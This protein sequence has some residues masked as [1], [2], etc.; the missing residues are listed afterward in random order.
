MGELSAIFQKL[1]DAIQD[2]EDKNPV[3]W[4][5][6]DGNNGPGKYSTYKD[7]FVEEQKQE[8]MEVDG[9][10]GEEGEEGED[11]DEGGGG[12]TVKDVWANKLGTEKG[13]GDVDEAMDVEDDTLQIDLR[14]IVQNVRDDSEEKEKWRTQ[15]IHTDYD[16]LPMSGAKYVS[17]PDPDSK[18]QG[19]TKPCADKEKTPYPTTSRNRTSTTCTPRSSALSAPSRLTTSILGSARRRSRCSTRWPPRP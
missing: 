9:E 3:G 1:S 12:S 4:E 10:E 18:L 14:I 11:D 8:A 17:V 6:S 2:A 19:A 15:V 13:G 5:V 7:E 16:N